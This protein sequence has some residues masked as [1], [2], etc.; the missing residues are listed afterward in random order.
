M[1]IVVPPVEVTPSWCEEYVASSNSRMVVACTNRSSVGTS[2]STT[3]QLATVI[4]H[5]L[6]LTMP[7]KTVATR[8]RGPVETGSSP[9]LWPNLHAA[10]LP[11]RMHGAPCR[12]P[13]VLC[14]AGGAHPTPGQSKA[15]EVYW[16]MVHT[17]YLCVGSNGVGIV[18]SAADRR[19][20][21]PCPHPSNN[22]CDSPL[23]RSRAAH[24]EATLKMLCVYHPGAPCHRGPMPLQSSRMQRATLGLGRIELK[25]NCVKELA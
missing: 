12:M 24:P 13:T 5:A 23:P 14:G 25:D 15:G 10:L 20:Q 3:T 1:M 18:V 4:L 16:W 8:S 7:K 11:L 9:V 6:H 17:C 19:L 21:R 2:E 22:L